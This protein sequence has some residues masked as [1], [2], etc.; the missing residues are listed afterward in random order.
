MPP[1]PLTLGTAGLLAA[2][3]LAEHRFPLRRQTQLEPARTLRNLVLGA[4]SMAVVAS[5]EA[6]VT[7]R[8]AARA[9]ERRHGAVQRLPLPRWARDALAVLMMDY[10][11]YVW[12]IMTHKVPLLWRFH[13][14][15]HLDL[16]LDASTALRFHA[17]DMLISI[18][19]RV[20]QVALIGVSRR[21]LRVWQACFFV[22]ILFHHSNLRLPARLERRLA[23]L[24]TTPRMHAIHHL[25]AEAETSAN[26]SSGLSV[27]DRLHGTFRLDARQPA[28]RI[29][30]PAYD[31]PKQ[32]WLRASLILPFARQPDAWTPAPAGRGTSP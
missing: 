7:H 23:A 11:I 27:W 2:I 32:T 19:Y 8:L 29:G 22:S 26:W 16:D 31:D 5:L 6:P 1:L 21:A 9:E 15:H 28:T 4:V 20:A 12:H 17:A 24:F 18:P 10:T 30:V 25:A 13:L 14:V 3:M